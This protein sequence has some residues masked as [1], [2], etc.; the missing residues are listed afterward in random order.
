MRVEI[1][2]LVLIAAV[3]YSIP[4]IPDLD[5]FE[6]LKTKCDKRGGNGTFTKIK[7]AID[8]TQTCVENL[9]DIDKFTEEL[10]ASKKTG[11]MDEVFAKY[12]KKRPD[13]RK[14]II[15]FYDALEPCLDEAEKK[16]LNFTN[17]ILTEISDFACAKDGDRLALFVAE[18]GPACI[19]SK[20]EGIQK[21]LN[22]TLQ[23]NPDNI[24]K[25]SIKLAIDKKTC[26]DLGKIQTCVVAE[27]E[28][29]E[30]STPANIVDALFKFAKRT[31]CKDIKKRS[32][33]SFVGL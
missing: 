5:D 18:G 10:E 6:E 21:C 11:S 14:C 33:L 4:T 8:E 15:Q 25:I 19:K 17:S 29:C 2:L 27:L 30:E 23:L 31:A 28:K 20:T 1:F 12:C 32:I 22:Q 13:V 16:G 9:I 3:C 26:D 7:T 24:P